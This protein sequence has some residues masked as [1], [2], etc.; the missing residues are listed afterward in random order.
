MTYLAAALFFTFALLA[1]A[2]VI[3]LEVRRHWIEILL[4]LRGEWHGVPHYRFAP[5][6]RRPAAR[7]AVPAVAKAPRR[8]AA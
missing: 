1:A 5:A 8:V 6:V 4:A 2:V 7:Q 3:H